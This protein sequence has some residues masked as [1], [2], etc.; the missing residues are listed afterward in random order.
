MIASREH[1]DKDALNTTQKVQLDLGVRERVAVLSPVVSLPVTV[2][3][4]I[5]AFAVLGGAASGPDFHA[6]AATSEPSIVWG[7]LPFILMGTM[8]GCMLV[9]WPFAGGA[10]VK[11]PRMVRTTLLGGALYLAA[12]GISAVL[13]AIIGPGLQLHSFVFA[14]IGAAMLYDAGLIR[15]AFRSRFARAG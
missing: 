7:D 10:S 3:H 1:S 12:T 8:F 15:R 13:F 2:H 5:I 14:A 11:R 4:L 6:V 9:F